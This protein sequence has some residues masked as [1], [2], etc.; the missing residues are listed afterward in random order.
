MSHVSRS[1]VYPARELSKV[2]GMCFRIEICPYDTQY[3][4]SVN[5][6]SHRTCQNDSLYEIM[7]NTLLSTSLITILERSSMLVC[8]K[9][10]IA[11][12]VSSI[13]P[14]PVSRMIRGLAIVWQC[15]QRIGQVR[16]CC[17]LQ[18]LPSGAGHI[19]MRV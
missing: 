10:S 12:S 5:P 6:F 7:H 14:S 11:Q 17:R 1:H 8:D 4:I 19:F 15:I 3:S 13:T 9:K 16:L 18:F 2:G